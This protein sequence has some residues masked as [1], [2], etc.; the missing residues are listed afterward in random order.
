MKTCP[1]CSQNCAQGRECPA[2]GRKEP[3]RP[4]DAWRVVF[5]VLV[6]WAAIAVAVVLWQRF[7]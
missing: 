3:P 2:M 7:I 4:G 6:P 5:A 1:P